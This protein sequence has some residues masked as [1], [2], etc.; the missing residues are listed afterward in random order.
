[1]NPKLRTFLSGLLLLTG[2]APAM[3]QQ[4]ADQKR[5]G[6]LGADLAVEIEADEAE[7]SE[8]RDTSI[9]RGNVRL[10]RGPLSMRGDELRIYRNPKDGRI[11]ATLSGRPAKAT[12][13]TPGD[14]LPVTASAR[15]IVYTTIIEILELEGNA[16]IERGSDRLSG[17]LVRYDVSNA[18]IEADGGRERVR[19]VINPPPQDTKSPSP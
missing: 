16:Q 8:A 5:P 2:L 4:A 11:E 19:I 7:L 9:Y 3:A 1:M 18:R 12:H 17:N 10:T 13:R 14:E 15:R 6:F